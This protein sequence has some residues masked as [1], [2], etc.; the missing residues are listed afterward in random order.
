MNSVTEVILVDTALYPLE[1]VEASLYRN[2]ES[3]VGEITKS[4]DGLLVS[5]TARDIKDPLS[6]IEMREAFLISLNDESLRYKIAE[7]TSQLRDLIL[8]HAFSKTDLE[9]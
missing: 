9:V 6:A 7:R 2:A 4:V 1:V 3:F 5:I 8:A